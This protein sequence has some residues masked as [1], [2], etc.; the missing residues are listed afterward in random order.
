LPAERFAKASRWQGE[1]AEP[2][3]HARRLTLSASFQGPAE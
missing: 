1:P 2:G 3:A